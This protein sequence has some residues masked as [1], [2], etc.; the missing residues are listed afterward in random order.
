MTIDH[1]AAPVLPR[2]VGSDVHWG[3]DCLKF[4]YKGEVWHGHVSVYIILGSEKTLMID[5]GHPGHWASI[6][7]HLDDVLGDRPLDYIMPTHTEMPHAGNLSRL[8][9]KYP[10]I[11]VVGEVRD[12]HLY[13]PKL[14]HR[15]RPVALF[16]SVDLGDRQITVLPAI[17]RDLPST[18][19][20]Y[21]SLSRVMFVADGFAYS[22]HHLQGE[23]A[24]FSGE[25][26]V[27]PD[28]EQTIFL[29]EKA[30]YWTRWVDAVSKEID[31][32][33]LL[34]DYPPSLVAP[35]H[36]AVITNLDT[37]L[38]LLREGMAANRKEH[39]MPP[40]QFARTI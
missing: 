40:A 10:A 8:V 28:V 31:M 34:A 37:M 33:K 30:L 13:Y 3:G 27:A 23:C 22:H 36:G 26:A 7:K 39:G 38:P 24:Q 12:Y 20:M 1:T 5:T 14:E 17:W 29:N 35:A 32:D 16:D 11:E 6:E 2:L 18:I 4:N 25:L 21:D 15:L 19:W 9:D